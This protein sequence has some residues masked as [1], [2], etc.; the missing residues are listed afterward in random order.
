MSGRSVGCDESA[1]WHAL[2]AKYSRQPRSSALLREP[3]QNFLSR[4]FRVFRGTNFKVAPPFAF[5][6]PGELV[7]QDLRLILR[8]T[9]PPHAGRAAAYRFE[10][11][12]VPDG[13]RLGRIE[14]R[15]G[16]SQDLRMYTGH[17]GYRVDP[18]HRGNHY[19]ARGCKLLTALA[20]AHG[21]AEIWITC[22]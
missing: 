10:M 15:V 13:A 19:A 12:R 21:M 22:D 18:L 1:G 2:D 6:A 14:L 4:V 8:E 20:R 5:L 9:V 17:I 3:L 7:D 11:R 16:D